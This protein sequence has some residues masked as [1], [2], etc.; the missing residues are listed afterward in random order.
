MRG[1]AD[2]C[3]LRA[4]KPSVRGPRTVP[5]L[6]EGCRGFDDPHTEAR[7]TAASP[8]RKAILR[9]AR[10]RE[11]IAGEYRIAC[12]ASHPQPSN[13]VSNMR[14]RVNEILTDLCTTGRNVVRDF[15]TWPAYGPRLIDEIEAIASVLL[16]IACAHLVGARNV[17]WA[18][19]SGYMVMR[20]HVTE[21]FRRGVLR[22]IG[23]AAGAVLAWCLSGHATGSTW[24]S[25]LLLMSVS[26]VTLYLALLSRRSY[27][28][29]FTGLTFSMVFIE[30]MQHPAGI[31]GFAWSR[32]IEVLTGTTACVCVSAV[33]TYVVRRRL[34]AP[35]AAAT[36]ATPT[37]PAA[38][39][40]PSADTHEPIG[41]NAMAFQHALQAGL[42]MGLIPWF[43][44]GFHIVAL[45]Q[46]SITI[47]AVMMV[48][49]S[50]LSSPHHPT[51]AKLLHRFAGCSIGG[52][53]ATLIL[54]T[55]H[56]LPYLMILGVCIGVAIGRHIENGKSGIGYV[57]TQ[58]A[59]AFL[60]VLVPDSYT[61]LSITPGLERLFGILFG[62][63]LLEPV[64]LGWRALI[65]SRD[66]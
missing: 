35:A 52:L 37:A 20:S 18:A 40:A 66:R 17:G 43:W 49:L 1:H 39:A 29:L 33:S 57:G 5:S 30:G 63:M 50:S 36:S 65:H 14:P 16:A 26:V 46:S 6:A 53:L 21:S 55:S 2:P 23:T 54:L 8:I 13:V 15:S 24:L 11:R 22:V 27:A 28:W 3:G 56:N 4:R 19:F 12:Q 64:R 61:N 62:M 31:G 7:G 47:L 32:F 44:H 45:S 38:A 48:P 42:A 9:D 59:L 60:V 34:P 25:S 41:W 58:F 10:K 51:S